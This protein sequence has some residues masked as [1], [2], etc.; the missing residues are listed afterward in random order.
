MTYAVAANGSDIGFPIPPPMPVGDWTYEFCVYAR[1]CATKA[2]MA[3]L[4]SGVFEYH[5]G[6]RGLKRYSLKELEAVIQFWSNA[7]ADAAL[8]TYSAIQCRRAV[9]CDV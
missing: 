1:N 8:G 2:L 9:P 6:S 3:A 4:N 5:I 7:A